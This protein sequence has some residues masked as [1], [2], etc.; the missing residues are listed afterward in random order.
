MMERF[1]KLFTKSKVET[2]YPSE[3]TA[4][5]LGYLVWG[6]EKVGKDGHKSRKM[7]KEAVLTLVPTRYV[8][9]DVLKMAE[10]YLDDPLRVSNYVHSSFC[11]YRGS[12]SG[13]FAAPHIFKEK[14][15]EW[16]EPVDFSWSDMEAVL[17]GG[18]LLGKQLKGKVEISIREGDYKKVTE[19]DVRRGEKKE[20]IEKLSIEDRLGSVMKYKIPDVY[21]VGLIAQQPWQMTSLRWY[22]NYLAYLRD[23][24]GK[25]VPVEEKRIQNLPKL[26]NERPQKRRGIST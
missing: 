3:M 21:S 10:K 12:V 26:I 4:K 20:K 8:P 7:G 5:E 23:D 18:K 11:I 24:L 25:G 6:P 14:I 1:G 13:E 17:A 19:I 15:L 22:A 9:L 16:P 2:S